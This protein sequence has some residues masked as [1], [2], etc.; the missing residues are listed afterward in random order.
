VVLKRFWI[1]RTLLSDIFLL[2]FVPAAV[3]GLTLSLMTDS[4]HPPVAFL[5]RFAAER[6]LVT[7]Y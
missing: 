4:R 1:F 6:S 7:L 5:L 2:G 3:R